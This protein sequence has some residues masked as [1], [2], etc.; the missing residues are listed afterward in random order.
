MTLG[1]ALG[2]PGRKHVAA[3]VRRVNRSLAGGPVAGRRAGRW[4]H[5]T[6]CPRSCPRR[7]SRCWTSSIRMKLPVRRLLAIGVEASGALV[8]RCTRP[9]S[10]SASSAGAAYALERVHVDAGRSMLVDDRRRAARGVL[11]HVAPARA[12]AGCSVIQQMSASQ[13]ARDRRRLVAARQISSP[14]E[15]S[16]SSSRRS[17]SDIG[18]IASSSSPS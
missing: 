3:R 4:V 15:T 13:L 2:E 6:P 17:V 10:L 1:C 18:A 8:R 12:A 16:S 9:M 14:R 5:V 11:D 7:P